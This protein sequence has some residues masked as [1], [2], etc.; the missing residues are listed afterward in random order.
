VLEGL[1]PTVAVLAWPADGPSSTRVRRGGRAL[2]APLV[3]GLGLPFLARHA[4][5]RA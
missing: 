2:L 3:Y 1:M 5:G 4:R